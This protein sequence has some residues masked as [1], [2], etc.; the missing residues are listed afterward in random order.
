MWEG[1]SVQG[2]RKSKRGRERESER[3][4]ARR[5]CSKIWRKRKT[6]KE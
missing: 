5:K 4:V 6:G 3:E 2:R 1:E